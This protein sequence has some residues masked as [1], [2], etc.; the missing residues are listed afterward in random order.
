MAIPFSAMGDLYDT[1][2][3]TG[4][5][6]D[7]EGQDHQ[8]LARVVRTVLAGHHNFR[9]DDHRAV[10]IAD[11]KQDYDEFAIVTTALKVLLAFIGPLTLRIAAIAPLTTILLS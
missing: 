4:I 8:Q 5:F 2:Y 6:M 9:P 11:F 3:I 1:Q 7:Y 10:F